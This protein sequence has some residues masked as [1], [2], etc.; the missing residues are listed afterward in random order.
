VFNS[1]I[2]A[3]NDFVL[4]MMPDDRTAIASFADRFQMRQPFSSDRDE[5][6]GHL[7]DEF[8]LRI[9][10]ETR[11]WES[12]IE[13]ILAVNHET[14]RR[15]VLAITDGWNMTNPYKPG[16]A[17]P[18]DVL[19]SAIGGD[20]MIYTIAMWTLDERYKQSQ[21]NRDVESLSTETGGGFVEVHESNDINKTLTQVS[22]ELHRQYVLGF[23]AAVL[24]GKTHKLD[25]RVKRPG[26]DVRARKSYVAPKPA[27]SAGEGGGRP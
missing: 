27:R 15:V 14:N 21:P 20:V 1:V 3:A 23:T 5:L 6:L 25:V 10:N 12:M 24:D 4:R 22:T 17:G 11:L 13:G 7:R 18:R 19:V 2:E 8:N 16:F 9:G 26:L